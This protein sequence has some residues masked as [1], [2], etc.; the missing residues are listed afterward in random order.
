MK[1]EKP[2]KRAERI[3]L[4][5]KKG[6]TLCC[7]NRQTEESGTEVIF[8]PAAILSVA[9]RLKTPSSTV[10]WCRPTMGYLVPSFP[11]RGQRRHE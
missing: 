3:A 10:C 5:C 8:Y 9:S 11:R 2:W 7:F 1:P 4:A 6:K